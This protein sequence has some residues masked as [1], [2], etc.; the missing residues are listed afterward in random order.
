MNASIRTFMW[1]ATP[2]G[3]IL[4]GFIGDKVGMTIAFIVGGIFILIGMLFILFS[5]VS[6]VK[7][8]TENGLVEYTKP[9]KNT[10]NQDINKS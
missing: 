5:K 3:A 7:A 1:G 10:S 9:L 4:G 8:I 6:K 2:L